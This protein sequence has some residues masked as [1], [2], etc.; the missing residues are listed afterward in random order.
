ML[1]RVRRRRS[2]CT[3]LTTRWC[4]SSAGRGRP[5][6]IPGAR[7]RIVPG[8]GH[9]LPEALVP[10][11]VEEIAGHCLKAEGEMQRAGRKTPGR[12]H[13][14]PVRAR[15]ALSLHGDARDSDACREPDDL[16]AVRA[17][18]GF[19]S[20]ASARTSQRGSISCRPIAAAS[21]RR[22][23][24]SIIR[25]GSSRTR[26]ISTIT[27]ATRRCRG[28]AA[29]RNCAPCRAATR[30]SARPQ[31]PAVGVPL[32]RGPRGRQFRR[33]RQSAS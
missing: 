3:A 12:L 30:G 14:T 17:A 28:P 19:L 13:E 1:H 33:L 4:R 21:S 11:L 26:S 15:R 10:L 2:S 23:S 8:M 31:A 32:H 27:S 9:F 6:R 5:P 7:L 29:W 25:P 20:S 16:Q 24:A 18:S 22:R